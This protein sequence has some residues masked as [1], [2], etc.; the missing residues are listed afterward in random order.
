MSFLP[1][2]EKSLLP[3]EMKMPFSTV[4]HDG[5]L[6]L[7]SWINTSPIINIIEYFPNIELIDWFIDGLQCLTSVQYMLQ[8]RWL[9]SFFFDIFLEGKNTFF[10]I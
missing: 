3:A 5:R 8:E 4:W 7:V 10:E 1:V 6:R 2:N 9:T